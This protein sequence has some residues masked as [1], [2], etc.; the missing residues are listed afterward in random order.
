M[1]LKVIYDP[2]NQLWRFVNKDTGDVVLEFP[3]ENVDREL[4]IY[5]AKEHGKIEKDIG[6]ED[7]EEDARNELLDWF[8]NDIFGSK[9]FGEFLVNEFETSSLK[10]LENLLKGENEND[11]E[12]KINQEGFNEVVSSFEIKDAKLFDDDFINR[13]KD[14]LKSEIQVD[15]MK[16]F[17]GYLENFDSDDRKKIISSYITDDDFHSIMNEK[18]G[19]ENGDRL[20]VLLLKGG[21]DG[22]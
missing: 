1:H 21:N 14:L 8:E 4:V 16:K 7:L 10:S 22:E 18:L 12:K 2:A 11:K 19:I 13:Y 9:E 5:F 6:W 17:N 20:K 3:L 15:D